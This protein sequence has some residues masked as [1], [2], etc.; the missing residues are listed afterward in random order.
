M[1][2]INRIPIN[3]NLEI[4]KGCRN[5]DCPCWNT[6]CSQSGNI[7]EMHHGLIEDTLE[8]L[9]QIGIDNIALYGLGESLF[10]SDLA[11]V[12]ETTKHILPNVPIHLNTD[13]HMMSMDVQIPPIDYFNICHK[14][15][16]HYSPFLNYSNAK[17]ITHIFIVRTITWSLLE[18]ID[19]YIGDTI[20]LHP[21]QHYMI[22]SI[23]DC[24]FGSTPQIGTFKPLPVEDGIPVQNSFPQKPVKRKLYIDVN[25]IVRKCMFST[26]IYDSA[27]KLISNYD[28]SECESCGM[29]AYKYIIDIN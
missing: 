2:S 23:W 15:G 28:R 26:T 22:G 5:Y 14:D 13:S 25:G 19:R 10:H 9:S 21:Y 1:P 7:V 4:L 20:S 3:V 6:T 29:G 18:N 16:I 11:K 24:E 8:E 27:S 17:K 12:V